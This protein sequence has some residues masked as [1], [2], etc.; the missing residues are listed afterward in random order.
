MVGMV[1]AFLAAEQEQVPI[2]P[3]VVPWVE[4]QFDQTFLGQ[5]QVQI[6]PLP[7]VPPLGWVWPHSGAAGRGQHQLDHPIK[8]KK[9]IP[10]KLELSPMHKNL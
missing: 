9:C 8:K 3:A 2:P 6:H 4:W 7:L 1:L 10:C 5:P